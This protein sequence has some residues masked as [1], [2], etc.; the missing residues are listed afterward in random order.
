M[1]VFFSIPRLDGDGNNWVRLRKQE[2]GRLDSSCSATE[3]L[4]AGLDSREMADW[5]IHLWAACHGSRPRNAKWCISRSQAASNLYQCQ[6]E[7]PLLLLI[8]GDDL[9]SA[10]YFGGEP[11]LH[12]SAMRRQITHFYDKTTSHRTSRERLSLPT[13]DMT[14]RILIFSS[15]YRVTV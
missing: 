15:G 4:S 9:K 12:S 5:H 6:I 3:S 10:L 13:H 14:H 11:P 2:G 8:A 7:S 1:S